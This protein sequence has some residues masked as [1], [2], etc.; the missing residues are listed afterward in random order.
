VTQPNA[1]DLVA[2]LRKFGS[3]AARVEA[4]TAAGGL[5]A[6][7]RESIAAF[8]NS[9]GGGT[10]ILGL[11]E[12]E[13]F[14]VVGLANPAKIMSDLGDMCRDAL[15]PPLQPAIELAEVDGKPVVLATIHELPREQKPCYVKSLGLNRGTYIRVGESDRRLTTEEVQQLVAE[16][17]Q[18]AFDAEV[19]TAATK[20]DLDPRALADYLRRLR[21][22]NPRLWA[23]ET[24]DTIL[25]MTRLLVPGPT[26]HLHPSM[27]A[28]LALG[29][30][31]QQQFPQ[32]NV[33]FVHYPTVSGE[34]TPSGVRFLDNVSIDGPIPLMA[35][36]AMA[37]VQRN[38][39]RRS[40]VA[41]GGR[42][43]IWE[44][45]PEALREAIVNAL[46][47][48]DL[49]P[50]S[51][52]T[53]VQI[54][55]YPD[56]LRIHNPGGLFGSIDI[57]HLGEEG[58]SSAR[59][60]LLMKL[61]EDISV[62]GEDRTI[63]ENRGSGVRVMIASLRHAGMSPPTFKDRVTAF[64]VIMPNYALLDDDTV[65]WLNH[66]G[67]EGL[68]DS[69]CIALAL[70]RRHEVLDNARYRAVT[71][72]TDSR[73]ATFELQD[74]VAR[75][76][77]DQDGVKGGA[78]YTLSEFARQASHDGRRPRPN[79]RLQIIQALELR[80]VLSK[81]DIA[82]LISA[83]D[84]TVEHWLRELK[85]S[86]DVEIAEGGRSVKTTTYRLTAKGLQLDLPI[87][88]TTG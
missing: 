86:G 28:Y 54:E 26:G 38:M 67:R 55:M 64:E 68:R 84:K 50:G 72:V 48:R 66:L 82:E 80:G 12:G 19:V 23:S 5:P 88:D 33:T 75:E 27:A 36:E 78:R 85:K 13:G 51:R 34:A 63:C 3:E 16:R 45:P 65:G 52:G 62:P 8:A 61:L 77:A 42:R 2:E 53:Q 60:A 37:A 24:D 32:L 18:P 29:R 9:P 57:D 83:G 74:L 44:Y 58:R 46:V 73:V 11:A 43:D 47:H 76:L 17:G 81:S 59:N 22:A 1:T 25:R 69:Q 21:E 41:A 49:S 39:T 79:R 6:A 70:M 40:L 14:T 71:G 4:K 20:D 87:A 10:L 31:P 15:A 30:Y 7:C 35:Q 56:R